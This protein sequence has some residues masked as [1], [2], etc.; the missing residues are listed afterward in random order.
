MKAKK[1]KSTRAGGKAIR[2]RRLAVHRMRTEEPSL[3]IREIAQRLGVP[4]S[5]VERDLKADQ[6]EIGPPPTGAAEPGNQRALKSGAFSDRQLAPIRQQAEEYARSRWPW[7]SDTDIALYAR[8]AARVELLGEYELEHGVVK[9]PVRGEVFAT[10]TQL[11]QFEARLDRLVRR[12]DEAA[13]PDAP[14]RGGGFAGFSGSDAVADDL[15]GGLSGLTQREVLADPVASARARAL[16]RRL[17]PTEAAPEEDAPH[18]AG[19]DPRPSERPEWSERDE[20]PPGA[21]RR[22]LPPGATTRAID[23]LLG[24]SE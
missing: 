12:F 18:S 4:K 6:P 22:E 17:G 13:P 21:V 15:I 11:G 19:G 10:S 9:D 16:L 23:D 24:G 3:S 8:M 2:R 7:V 14:V 1:T 5:T 20:L